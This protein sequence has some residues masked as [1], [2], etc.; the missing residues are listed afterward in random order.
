MKLGLTDL[1]PHENTDHDFELPWE[2]IAAR[3][4]FAGLVLSA[5]NDLQRFKIVYTLR[6]DYE[7][8]VKLM[9]HLA[10]RW[11]LRKTS[12]L[13]SL[14]DCLEILQLDKDIFIQN[15]ESQGL[16]NKEPDPRP[17]LD[18]YEFDR[19]PKTIPKPKGLSRTYTPY[20]RPISLH[21]WLAHS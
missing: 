14:D 21:E 3:N 8:T 4:L 6:K 15:L 20:P 5:I 17:L 16:L 1:Q 13:I 19:D 11:I 9:G 7:R 2:E 12:A 18:Y 10:R